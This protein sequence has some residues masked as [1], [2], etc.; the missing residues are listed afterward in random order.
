MCC[1]FLHIGLSHE[2]RSSNKGIFESQILLAC[3]YFS[4]CCCVLCSS[5]DMEVALWVPQ[6]LFRL[7]DRN[8]Y[9][10]SPDLCNF[11]L[12]HAGSKEVAKPR[13]K[14]R[15]SVEYKLPEDGIQSG[16]LSWLQASKGSSKLLQPKCFRDNVTDPQVLESSTGQT[17]ACWRAWWTRGPR[18]CMHRSS[19]VARAQ[20]EERP[21][22]PV[23]F[24][25]FSTPCS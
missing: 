20:R 25:W 12:V 8:Y 21:D 6:W 22:M 23:S 3:W 4:F 18:S 9:C 13:F 19:R 2:V 24:W 14:I 16:R 11:E 15:P 1:W 7:R 5:R 17:A 10:S